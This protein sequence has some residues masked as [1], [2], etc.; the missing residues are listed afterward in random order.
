MDEEDLDDSG[1]TLVRSGKSA[2]TFTDMAGFVHDLETRPAPR[3]L[4][5]LPGLMA[6]PEAKFGLVAMVLRRKLRPES[7]ERAPILARLQELQSKSDDPAVR[8]RCTEL[9]E[10][11]L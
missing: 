2:L 10:R 7:P 1:S 4:L 8:Q 3:L 9:R 5:D 6:L 11:P